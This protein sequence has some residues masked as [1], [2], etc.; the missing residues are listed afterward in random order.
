MSGEGGE[1]I[2]PRQCVVLRGALP[3]GRLGR[4]RQYPR[5]GIHLCPGSEKGG[6]EVLRQSDAAVGS[7]GQHIPPTSPP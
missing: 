2:F 1:P 4:R 6:S 3:P 7:V 5:A